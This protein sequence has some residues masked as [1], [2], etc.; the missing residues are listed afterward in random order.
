MSYSV[1]GI[2]G[3]FENIKKT[4]GTL[5]DNSPLRIYINKLKL[6]LHLTSN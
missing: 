4:H 6:E 3:Y 5:T 2:Q 1:L